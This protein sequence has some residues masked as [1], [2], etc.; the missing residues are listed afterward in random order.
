VSCCGTEGRR[1]RTGVLANTCRIPDEVFDVRLGTSLLRCSLVR[2]E[3]KVELNVACQT[4]A[5]H[6]SGYRICT[7]PHRRPTAAVR[8]PKDD[9]R[10]AAAQVVAEAA[11]NDAEQLRRLAE[12][13]REVRDQHR[14]TAERSRQGQEKFREAAETAR[15][16]SEE[17]RRATEDA[18]HA[19]VASLQATAESLKTTLEQMTV[20]EEMRRILREIRDR[21]KL[22]S[23]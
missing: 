8:V 9:R 17:T 22:D 13:M 1:H 12:E 6:L 7:T 10:Y 4:N 19:I 16:A 2:F 23:H 18:R 5:F 3:G 15:A 14:E 21:S 11:R 20:V